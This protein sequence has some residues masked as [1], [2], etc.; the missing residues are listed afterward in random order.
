M[1]RHHLYKTKLCI[2]F[3]ATGACS[4]DKRCQFAHGHQELRIVRVD[5]HAECQRQQLTPCVCGRCLVSLLPLPG[6]R[7]KV[8]RLIPLACGFVS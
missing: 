7:Q 5:A 4:Y 6:H 3:Q 2:Q 1:K 8:P